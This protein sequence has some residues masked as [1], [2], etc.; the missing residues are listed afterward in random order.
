MAF[1]PKCGIQVADGTLFCPELRHADPAGGSRRRTSRYAGQPV[2]SSRR[3]ISRAGT[4][5]TGSRRRI[6]S[7][8]DSRSFGQQP[9]GQP[10]A[11]QPR[12]RAHACFRC[13]RKAGPG[14]TRKEWLC[15]LIL[16]FLFLIPLFAARDDEFVQFP[17]ESG[18]RG[19][20]RGDRSI[21]IVMQTVGKSGG[22]IGLLFS[23][24]AGLDRL[25]CHV[26]LLRS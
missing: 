19:V 5:H 18:H 24:L 4:S 10:Y 15:C 16:V 6:T 2:Y 14:G 25:F 7:R 21:D 17:C 1:C 3:I 26:H 11:Q 12:S 20:P 9:Q 13:E 8:M 23:I 22:I